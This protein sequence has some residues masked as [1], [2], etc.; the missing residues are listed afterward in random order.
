MK[1][2]SIFS[3]HYDRTRYNTTRIGSIY[4][5]PKNILKYFSKKEGF[6]KFMSYIVFRKGKKE[7]NLKNII[8]KKVKY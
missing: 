1:W 2:E 8:N 5:I 7:N 6:L 4:K 3:Y